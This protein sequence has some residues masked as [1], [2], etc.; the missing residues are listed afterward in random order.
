MSELSSTLLKIQQQYTKKMQEA[1]LN[2]DFALL[3]SLAVEMRNEIEKAQNSIVS[4]SSS[5]CDLG[6]SKKVLNKNSIST[7]YAG[8]TSS[9]VEVDFSTLYPH[10]S[11]IR[12]KMELIIYDDDRDIFKWFM[13]Q[14]KF[15]NNLEKLKESY[16]GVSATKHL[17][18][19]SFRLTPKLAPQVF[20]M[21]ELSKSRLGIKQDFDLY[22]YHDPKFN[23]SIYS[24][25]GQRNSRP[26]ILLTS[27]IIESFSKEE[28]LFVIGHEIGH[29]VFNHYS[30]PLSLIFERGSDLIS[31]LK[32]MKL[33][34]WGRAAEITADRV[35]LLCCQNL[36][37]AISS[38]F[39]LSSGTI[40]TNL[41]RF[42]L[43]E[44]LIQFSDLRAMM[45]QDESDSRDWYSS[46]P[47]SPLRI[48]AL[49]LFARSE[50]YE[51]L[52]SDTVLENKLTE[53]ELEE[54][55]R[56]FMSMMSPNY[57]KQEG[58]RGE[59]L[60][61]FLLGAGLGIASADGFYDPGERYA[62]CEIVG[63]DFYEKNKERFSTCK[64]MSDWQNFLS[65]DIERLRVHTNN[66]DRRNLIRDL[67]IVAL[68][69]GVVHENERSFLSY[70]SYILGVEDDFIDE[71][72]E[73]LLSGLD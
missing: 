57:L 38:F 60:K 6:M 71:S 18:K 51:K 26:S 16:K 42:N 31:P 2:G 1:Q 33:S 49:E 58:E 72:I 29:Y 56:S 34:S 46:H 19:T 65:E 27:S 61:M 44:Y 13:S 62:I 43:D 70:L 32:A 12:S 68:S 5:D 64:S 9:S 39:K 35:G 67:S 30:L 40:S 41:I 45:V 8:G 28:L 36:N 3:Q 21:V 73:S 55:I 25:D 10:G 54:E 24:P 14:E 37:A 53:I 50:T 15:K 11:D 59:V 69:D 22:V 63:S 23:A 47:F 4:D 52:S 48:K 66:T 20:E 7:D 17:L